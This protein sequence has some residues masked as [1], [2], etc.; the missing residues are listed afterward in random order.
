MLYRRVYSSL[1]VAVLMFAAVAPLNTHSRPI[2]QELQ[3]NSFVAR[4]AGG[5]GTEQQTPDEKALK[6]ERERQ[7]KAEKE[8]RKEQERVEKQARQERERAEKERKK[9][10][11]RLA[12]LGVPRMNISTRPGGYPLRIDGQPAGETANY[13]RSIE[14]PRADHDPVTHL[15]EISFPNNQIWRQ[16]IAF[17]AGRT[18][19]VA[20]N[21]RP[22]S[23]SI[24][25]DGV[26]ATPLAS[27]SPV[28]ASPTP[29]RAERSIHGLSPFA[30]P[31]VSLTPSAAIVRDNVP[32]VFTATISQTG[33]APLDVDYHWTT[34]DGRMRGDNQII[35]SNSNSSSITVETE[36]LADGIYRV[37][38][39]VV[40]DT[41]NL[42]ASAPF[43]VRRSRQGKAEE[44]Q[45]RGSGQGQVETIDVGE[46]TGTAHD[47]GKANLAERDARG[48]LF[49][50]TFGGG[51]PKASALPPTR[52]R[53]GRR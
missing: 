19:C 15:V 49:A 25:T 47:C 30:P 3:T 13:A 14:F 29:A 12:K 41:A 46:I 5:V 36:G 38:V 40:T 21:Y 22:L 28:E 34:S 9:E 42:F 43:V 18:E 7:K 10:A 8:A 35:H 51:A 1:A 37:G 48:G 45:F 6:E 27:P 17:Y 53:R 2:G 26:E 39:E 24:P 32:V 16:E 33:A 44:K 31:T 23:I 52:R 20:V 11:R 4:R 50:A